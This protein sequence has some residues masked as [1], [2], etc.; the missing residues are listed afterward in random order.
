M[1]ISGVC[2]G[3]SSKNANTYPCVP[4]LISLVM[5]VTSVPRSPLSL[6]FVVF[7]TFLVFFSVIVKL[8]WTSTSPMVDG[9]TQTHWSRRG[10]RLNIHENWCNSLGLGSQAFRVFLEIENLVS[11]AR[12]CLLSIF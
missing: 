4:F 5:E 10:L 8:E 12:L 6:L 1:V 2:L 9:K 3:V 11:G 7:F